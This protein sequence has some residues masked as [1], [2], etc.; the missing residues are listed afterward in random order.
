M[1]QLTEIQLITRCKKDDR[2]AQKLLYE[3]YIDEM[4]GVSI[5]YLRDEQI[6]FE[7]L[8]QSFLK[9]FTNIL[10]FEYQEEGSLRGWI[11]RIVI[12]EALMY[13]RKKDHHLQ[14]LSI[15]DDS[16]QP[17]SNE[18]DNIDGEYL[19]ECI[20]KLPTGAGL[21]FNLHTIEGF[22]HKEIATQLNIEESSS[23]SQ[24]TYAK[25]LLR[26]IIQKGHLL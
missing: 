20:R 16:I 10:T 11:K 22:S 7:V 12:N 26:S 2:R 19:H 4:I 6:A 24:L 5:R 25:K 1:S 8:N 15:D 14:M 13:L 9:V 23:R 17:T 3:E 21:V 18:I